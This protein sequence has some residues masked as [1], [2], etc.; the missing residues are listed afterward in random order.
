METIFVSVASYR[1]DE[2]P[3]TLEYIFNNADNPQNVFV[4]ICQQNDMSK[5]SPDIECT[6]PDP[7]YVNNIR[8]MRLQHYE[9]KGP[10]WARYLCSTLYNNE[11]YFFQIDSHTKLVP[12]WDTKCINM[13]KYIKT[14][15]MSQ[16]PVLSHYPAAWESYPGNNSNVGGGGVTRICKSFFN[17]QGMISFEG[18]ESI[19]TN[20]VFPS[21]YIAG[22]FLFCDGSLLRDVPFDPS[23]D[24]LFVG[25][26]ILHSIRIWTSGYDIFTPN[27]NIAYH[28]YTRTEKPKIWT[29]K[30]YTDDEAFEKVKQLIGLSKMP[31]S[32]KS[33]HYGLGTVRSLNDYYNFAGINMK[34]KTVNK[35]FC[36]KDFKVDPPPPKGNNIMEHFGNSPDDYD[37]STST[38]LLTCLFY[39]V[40]V[41]VICYLYFTVK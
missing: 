40:L 11:T 37:D 16:K 2:C 7:R 38:G 10:T 13:M 35:N 15:G 8:L 23:L 33:Y 30:V 9:A 32:L 24:Y 29:D 34:N 41:V 21:P 26:E 27:E 12:G 4:G 20:E 31:N 1:D 36:R 5:G 6:L 14:T 19:D 25:E 28:E 22:G 3:T 18:A 17:E 39:I